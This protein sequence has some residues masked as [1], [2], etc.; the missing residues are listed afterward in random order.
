MKR[1]LLL[2][3]MLLLCALVAGSGSVWADGDV[4]YVKV[5]SASELVDGG[6]YIIGDVTSTKAFAFVEYNTS[7]NKGTGVSN[8][9]SIVGNSIKVASEA[10]KKPYEFILNT[11]SSANV[12]TL[13]ISGGNYL[14]YNSGTNFKR[15]ES[16][17]TSGDD[18]KLCQWTITYNNT[19]SKFTMVNVKKTDR[20]ILRKNDASPNTYGPYSN[21]NM[22]NSNYNVAT[23]YRKVTATISTAQYATFS[24]TCAIDFSGTGITVYTATDNKNSVTLNEVTGKKIPANTPVVLYKA[25]A[26]GNAIN[27]TV[28]ASADDPEGTNDLRVKDDGDDVDNMFVLA[29]PSGKEVGFYSWKG[30]KLNAGKV[31]LQ[32]KPSYDAREFLGFNEGSTT[33]I[34]AI[35]NSQLDNDAPMYNLAGQRVNKSYKGVVIVDGKKMLNK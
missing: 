7:N 27:L 20:V 1:N 18:L 5:T 23:L 17:P 6:T 12:F 28:I 33:G 4:Y 26:N 14:A 34:N 10:E 30:T 11:T 22:S 24:S 35:N 13:K 21:T 2:K 16:L 3:T 15:V 29:K 25:D 31:Y 32:G 19:Y 9:F 8:G